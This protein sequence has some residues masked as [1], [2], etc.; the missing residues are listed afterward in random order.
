MRVCKLVFV[1]QVYLGYSHCSCVYAGGYVC[2]LRVMAV[3][4]LH[5]G[6]SGCIKI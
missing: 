5:S 6:V 2:V 4:C 1:H 3:T